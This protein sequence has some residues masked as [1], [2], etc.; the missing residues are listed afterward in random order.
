MDEDGNII[1]TKKLRN[2]KKENPYSKVKSRYK[3]NVDSLCADRRSKSKSTKEVGYI[4]EEDD[5]V[6]ENKDTKQNTGKII[7]QNNGHNNITNRIKAKR[8]RFNTEDES[9]Y[10]TSLI[11]QCKILC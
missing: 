10:M 11:N 8:G 7:V 1:L 4:W 3:E 5:R 2:L 9:S 6:E